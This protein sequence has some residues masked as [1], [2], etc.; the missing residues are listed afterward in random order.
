MAITNKKP[1]IHKGGPK[2]D[3]LLTDAQYD[4]LAK[5]GHDPRITKTG[6]VFN[7][8]VSRILGVPVRPL[9][10][11]SVKFINDL[12]AHMRADAERKGIEVREK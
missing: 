9:T 11:D 7:A 1:K 6:A 8:V 12:D 2:P 3:V 10:E 4:E 5:Q